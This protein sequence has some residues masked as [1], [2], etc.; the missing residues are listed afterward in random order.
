MGVHGC[1]WVS[2]DCLRYRA[3]EVVTADYTY[4]ADVYSLGVV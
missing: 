1:A 4:T 2:L 3:P